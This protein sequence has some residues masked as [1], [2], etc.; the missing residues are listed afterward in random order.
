M[1]DEGCNAFSGEDAA[2]ES[3]GQA[4]HLNAS[5]AD[6]NTA[7]SGEQSGAAA[8]CSWITISLFLGSETHRSRML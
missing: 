2:T 1:V 8:V 6:R 3:R 4:G 7:A 5:I